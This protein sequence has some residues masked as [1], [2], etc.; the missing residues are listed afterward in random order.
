VIWCPANTKVVLAPVQPR[1]RIT[2]PI[3]LGKIELVVCREEIIFILIILWCIVA[4]M[5]WHSAPRFYSGWWHD[6]EVIAGVAMCCATV[7]TVLC[8]R[9]RF[10]ARVTSA[11]F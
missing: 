10:A 1:K 11:L 5:R 6:R 3:K 2:G 4:V 8:G 7:G 9:H